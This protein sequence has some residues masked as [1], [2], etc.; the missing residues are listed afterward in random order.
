MSA[1]RDKFLDKDNTLLCDIDSMTELELLE[2]K[3]IV[4]N[5]GEDVTYTSGLGIEDGALVLSRIL[6]REL[7]LRSRRE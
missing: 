4:I 5:D 2:F 3:K 7:V 1:C 6:G